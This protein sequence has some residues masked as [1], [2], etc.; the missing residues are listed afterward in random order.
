VLD[1][2]KAVQ[3]RRVIKL[4]HEF[5]ERNGE[6]AVYAFRARAASL[7]LLGEVPYPDASR[8]GMQQVKDALMKDLD[9]FEGAQFLRKAPSFATWIADTTAAYEEWLARI[10]A[11]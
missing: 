5:A 6:P 7:P 8:A 3:L 11:R 10:A 1:I 4:L 2:G 9:V